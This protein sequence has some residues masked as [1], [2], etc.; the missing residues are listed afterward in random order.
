MTVKCPFCEN[1]TVITAQLARNKW[2]AKCDHGCFVAPVQHG[3]YYDSR[4][5]AEEYIHRMAEASDNHGR[6]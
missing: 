5:M 3:V 2:K 6:R 1:G 4:Q